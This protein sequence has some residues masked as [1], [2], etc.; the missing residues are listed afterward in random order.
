[1]R[2]LKKIIGAVFAFVKNVIDDNIGLYAAQASFFLIISAI[3]FI[4]LL[5]ALVKYIVPIS[6]SDIFNFV[7]TYIPKSISQWVRAVID[8]I[9]NQSSNISIISV[10][11]ITTLWL[12][13]RG[14]MA[15]YSGINNAFGVKNVPNYFYTRIIAVFY[16]ICFLAVLIL[17]FV[18]FALGNKIQE[19][20]Y[21]KFSVLYE[22]VSFILSMRILI[23]FSLVTLCLAAIYKF[24]TRQRMKFKHQLPGAALATVG[25]MGFSYAYSIYIEYFSTYSYVYGSLTALVFL[26][27]WLYFC[28]DIFLYG[29]EFNKM[30]MPINRE[31]QRGNG[32]V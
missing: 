22:I 2:I 7:N 21:G 27:L 18:M 3:P 4:M 10:T 16:T 13:S 5:L 9:F 17:G 11:A 12:S 1:M 25:W 20:L 15:I 29:A 6:E 31:N 32:D 8:E 28:M 14:F 30:F 23:F 19:L 24:L 26:M